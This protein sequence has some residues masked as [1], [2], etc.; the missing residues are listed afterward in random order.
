M[1]AAVLLF[2][3]GSYASA[4]FGIAMRSYAVLCLL[5]GAALLAGCAGEQALVA[6]QRRAIDSLYV[7]ERALRADVY[8]LQDTLQFYD[9]VETGQYFRERRQMLN[10]IDRLE[11]MV[12]VRRDSLCADACAAR[13]PRPIDT[14]RVDALFEPAS[15]E[16]TEDGAERLAA[17]AERL[18]TDFSGRSFRIE[19][20]ADSV[21]PGGALK[22]QYPSNWELS[23]ARATA[24]VRHLAEVHGLP[25]ERFEAVSFGATRPV[26]TNRTAEGRSR[27]RRLVIYVLGAR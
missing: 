14:L 19:G 11:Y 25:P 26:D 18:K 12:A 2:L 3:Q 1:R 20:H 16:L 22:E 24:A 4:A 5:T 13:D 15:A 8:A 21:P 10:R 23:A 27:N 9:A 7:V 17:L 6:E